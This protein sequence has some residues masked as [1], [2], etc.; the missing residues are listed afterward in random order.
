MR[1]WLFYACLMSAVLVENVRRTA[2][3]ATWSVRGLFAR[4]FLPAPV[5][6]WEWT[7]GSPARVRL[8]ALHLDRLARC[9]KELAGDLGRQ[10]KLVLRLGSPKFARRI[11]W[12]AFHHWK[13]SAPR[14]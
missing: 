6:S 1:G 9:E 8:R 5:P 3:R 10:A 11:A 7:V 4:I 12:D 14:S 13:N 2:R